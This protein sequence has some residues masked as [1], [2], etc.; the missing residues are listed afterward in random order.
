[1]LETKRGDAPSQGTLMRLIPIAALLLAG[2]TSSQ[3]AA[4]TGSRDGRYLGDGIQPPDAGLGD[5]GIKGTIGAPCTPGKG[6]ECGGSECL[7]VGGGVGVCSVRGCVPEDLKTAATEDNCP[8]LPS[9][10]RTVC[11]SLT[12]KGSTSAAS[13]CLPK[14]TPSASKNA[15]AGLVDAKLTCDPISLLQNGWSEV[16]MLPACTGDAECGNR[17]PLNPDSKCDP[18]TGTCRVRGVDGVK[19]G[20]RCKTSTECGPGQFCYAE[21]KDASGKTIAEGGYCTVIGCSYG[22]PW[23]CPTGSAC[24]VLGSAKAFSY[25]LATGCSDTAPAASDGCRDEA[26]PE[27][28]KCVPQ[29][30]GSPSV[31][32]PTLW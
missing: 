24:V 32:V 26:A 3:P 17:N 8:A 27:Q 13:Y 22:G 5:G 1:M 23:S 15:C 29:A 21:H 25:C 4:D 16:C 30:K 7:D 12:P 6:G 10:V 18:T 2:C 20:S 19:V 11:T 28:Y 9:G 14:C 31:C